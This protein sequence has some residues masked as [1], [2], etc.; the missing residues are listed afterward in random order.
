MNFR[1]PAYRQVGAGMTR[2]AVIKFMPHITNYKQLAKTPLRKKALAIVEAGYAAIEITTAIKKRITLKKNTLEVIFPNEKQGA[3]KID[4]NDYKR[5]FL[6]G[7]GK[8]SALA[9]ASLAQV[10]GKRLTKGIAIDVEQPKLA[11]RNSQLATFIGTHPLPSA[12]NVAATKKIIKMISGLKADD[13]VIMFMCGGGSALAVASNEELKASTT[14]FK[15]LTK[16]GANIIELN[17]V[18]KHLS[19]IKGGNLAKA[20]YPAA[21]LT[22]MASDVIGNDMEMIAS[23]PTVMDTTTKRD[24]MTVLKKY[25]I[26][27]KGLEFKETPKDKKYF[28]NVNNTLFISNGDAAQAMADEAKRLGLQAKIQSTTFQGEAKSA[29]LPAMRAIKKGEA[30]IMAGET[31]VTLNDVPTGEKIGKGGR[32]Q[33]AVLGVLA[34]SVK[35]GLDGIV[36]ISYAS[37]GRDNTEAAGAIGDGE[38]VRAIAK[39]KQDIGETLALHD[40]FNFF[41]KNGNLLLVKRNSFNVADLMLIIRE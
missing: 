12:K 13:L 21:M 26:S 11:T 1:L 16:A 2:K 3:V 31:T 24:A 25:G 38:T 5:V 17:T 6:V 30:I 32:N 14:V 36:A 10:L 20:A 28:T 8:G 35:K 9:S 18:R 15:E 29:L 40:T 22:L 23:G 34:N 37:D 19:D 27:T 4:L 41:K 33:E 39:T 7:I